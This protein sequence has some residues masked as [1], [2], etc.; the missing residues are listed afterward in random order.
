MVP[1]NLA[2]KDEI[3]KLIRSVSFHHVR[4]AP[5]CCYTVICYVD[6]PDKRLVAYTHVDSEKEIGKGKIEAYNIAIKKMSKKYEKYMKHK[7]F[8]GLSKW[9]PN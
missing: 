3:F 8:L 9:P 1:E 5:R 6:I 4:N 2:Y 7:D